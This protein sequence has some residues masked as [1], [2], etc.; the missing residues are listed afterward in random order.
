[1]VKCN[2]R[3]EDIWEDNEKHYI[4][5]HKLNG[6]PLKYAESDHVC[7]EEK[8]IFQQILAYVR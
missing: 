4:C 5:E 6:Q 2:F 7:A 3:L 1:M 8:C